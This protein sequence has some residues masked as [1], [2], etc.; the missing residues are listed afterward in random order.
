MDF[1][2][3]IDGVEDFAACVGELASMIGH[4]GRVAVA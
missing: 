2:A 1:A 3:I 4:V